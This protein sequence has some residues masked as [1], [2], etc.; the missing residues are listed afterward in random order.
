M[1]RTWVPLVGPDVELRLA[2]APGRESRWSE[3]AI[4]SLS[5]LATAFAAAVAPH[6]DRPFALFGHSLGALV[7]FE[8]AR[9]LRADAGVLPRHLV[10]SAH[11]APDIPNRYTPLAGLSDADFVGQVHARHGGIP[12]AVASN[13]ELM[14]LMLPSLRADYRAFEE[15]R[16]AVE[17]PLAC[18]ITA[19]GG[20]TDSHVS[21]EDLDG[22]TRHTARGFRLQMFEGGHFFVN[23][24]RPAVVSA[25]L[26]A[27]GRA[28]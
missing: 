11:R 25:V 16:H 27:V 28:D 6:T 26:D 23:D 14:D 4:P 21:R 3:P 20:T 12:E 13:R 5:D 7:A 10:V 8:V 22:W 9:R 15:Y 18:P 2:H 1:F 19:F 17:E 24:L